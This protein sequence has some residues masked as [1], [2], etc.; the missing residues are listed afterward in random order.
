[1]Q[2]LE[3]KEGDKIWKY[4]FHFFNENYNNLYYNCL[5]TKCK[6]KGIYIINKDEKYISE[7]EQQPETDKFELSKDHD[8]PYDQHNY[9]IINTIIKDMN[10]LS[11]NIIKKIRKLLL[12]N[13]FIKAF[14]IYNIN[15]PLTING[16]LREIESTYG[17]IKINF[18]PINKDDIQ[19]AKMKYIKKII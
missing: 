11:T 18:D 2:Y 5:D 3:I 1:M 15:K 13:N 17:K 12:L 9:N 10:T 8:I 7:K 14:A 19:K 6:G 4:S 16:L